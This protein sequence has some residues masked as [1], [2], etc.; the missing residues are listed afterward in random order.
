MKKGPLGS[1]EALHS[2]VVAQSHVE[3]VGLKLFDYAD[4]EDRAAR[5]TK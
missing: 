2:E 3:A 4:T 1:E 5:F